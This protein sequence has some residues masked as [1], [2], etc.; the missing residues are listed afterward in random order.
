MSTFPLNAA[1]GAGISAISVKSSPRE[2]NA[3]G[4]QPAS[5][6]PRSIENDAI[7]AI[8]A[9]ADAAP[10]QAL[11]ERL[12][13][14][15]RIAAQPSAYPDE[16]HRP[17]RPLYGKARYHW[18]GRRV[19]MGWREVQFMLQDTERQLICNIRAGL[20]VWGS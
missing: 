12:I 6:K 2:N 15:E 17:A 4:G 8:A 16:A 14:L 7:R 11:Q 13:E 3:I 9:Q 10:L 19:G 1:K 18:I 20:D 5:F